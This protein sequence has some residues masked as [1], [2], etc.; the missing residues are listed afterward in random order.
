MTS[1]LR[2][3]RLKLGGLVVAVGL[4]VLLY[5]A[6]G[7]PK[8]LAQWKGMDIVGEGGS[9]LLVFCWILLLLKSRPSGRVTTLLFAGLSG[10]LLSL[11]M[12]ALDELIELPVTVNWDKWLESG[13]MPVGLLLITLGIYH[14]HHEQLAIAGQMEKREWAFREHRLFDHLTPLSGGRYLRRQLPKVLRNAQAR[15]APL[16][17]AILDL[18]D[19]GEFTRLHGHAEADRVLQVISQLLLLNLRRQDLLCRLAGDR[20]VVVLPDTAEHQARQMAWALKAAVE[21][22]AYHCDRD[23]KRLQLSASVASVTV[24]QEHAESEEDAESLLERLNRALV[25]ARQPLRVQR[26]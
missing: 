25:R 8:T 16:S 21:S 9:A 24:Q 1:F 15:H 5:L 13:P 3:H 4:E 10:V 6:A 19:F 7:V 2:L 11:W 20:F 18:D 17:L 22:L 14:W 26:A 23:A 12:D